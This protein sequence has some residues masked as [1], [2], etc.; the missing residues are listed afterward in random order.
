ME[1]NDMSFDLKVDVEYFRGKEIVKMLRIGGMTNQNWLVC[2]A[3]GEEVVLRIPGESSKAFIDRRSEGYNNL[4][5]DKLGVSPKLLSFDGD[6]GVKVCSFI[7][8]AETLSPNGIWTYVDRVVDLLG[9]YHTS[10]ENFKNKYS[11]RES[12]DSYVRLISEKNGKLTSR[13]FRLM[14]SVDYLIDRLLRLG[15]E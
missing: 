12:Y 2:F 9:R 15:V 13:D 11:F 14:K 3:T 10:N 5:M 1:V 4:L 8:G 7:D 6:T